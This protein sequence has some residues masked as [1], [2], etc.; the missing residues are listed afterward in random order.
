[1]IYRVPNWRSRLHEWAVSQVGKSFTWGE[2][3]CA[4][5]AREALRVMF[6]TEVISLPAWRSAS[7]GVATLAAHGAIPAILE[8]VGG[9]QW[10]GPAFLRAGDLVVL[11]NNEEGVGA[12][13][14]MVCVDARQC[15]GSGPGGVYLTNLP[16]DCDARVFSVWEIE[17][18]TGEALDG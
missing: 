8:R 13:A 3:D 18:A 11:P 9:G 6:D 7:E 14:M 16:L 5:L 10:T 17:S 15:L 1:M 2:T 12:Y 4:S